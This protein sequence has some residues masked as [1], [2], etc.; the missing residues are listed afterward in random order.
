[1]WKAFRLAE[2]AL[3]RA[4][5]RIN[6]GG[7]WAACCRPAALLVQWSARPGTAPNFIIPPPLTRT[8]QLIVSVEP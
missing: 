6:I 4:G 8:R 1:M 3:K 7:K 5:N 2:A